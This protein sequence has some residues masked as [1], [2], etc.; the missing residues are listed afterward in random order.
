LE[1]RPAQR[2][3][4]SARFNTEPAH[5]LSEPLEAPVN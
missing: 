1:L 3:S 2:Q 5:L 4:L